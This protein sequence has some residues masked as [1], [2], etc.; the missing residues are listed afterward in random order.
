MNPL[1]TQAQ[2]GFK[3]PLSIPSFL[4]AL[5]SPPSQ[6]APRTHTQ[7]D[8]LLGLIVFSV[9]F[10]SLSASIHPVLVTTATGEIQSQY[11]LAAC[12]PAQHAHC[13]VLFLCLFNVP[14]PELRHIWAKKK[15]HM[16]WVRTPALRQSFQ[17]PLSC[18]FVDACVPV[19]FG[20]FC[21]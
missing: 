7:T 19:C 12:H 6:P 8:I 17:V 3:T 4:L 15:L 16:V 10:L 18:V 2:R 11:L 5:P 21:K 9:L 20:T 14:E 13:W 1:L